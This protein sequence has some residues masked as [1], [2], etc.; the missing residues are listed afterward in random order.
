MVD[1]MTDT[2]LVTGAAGNL[3]RKV[4]DFLL[5]RSPA[6]KIIATTRNPDALSAYAKR[7]VDVRR[8]DFSD[9]A[10]LA[11]A[12]RGATRALLISTDAVGARVEGHKAAIAAFVAAG[13]THVV[14]TSIPNPAGSPAGVAPDHEQ[15]E[16]AIA[17]TSLDYTILRNSLYADLLLGMLPGAIASGTLVDAKGTAALA[18]V[19]REDCARAAAAALGGTHG[20]RATY[21]VTGPKALTGTELASIVSEVTGKPVTYLAVPHQAY[22]DGMISHGL[23]PFLAELFASFDQAT[24]RGDYKT[25]APTVQ[26]LAGIAPTSVKDF[27]IANRAALGV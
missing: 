5:E 24:V 13:V 19:T 4:L 27:L 10:S 11:P 21:D 16:A 20:G 1:R 25:V 23:P 2:L 8:A 15:T 17:A 26:Q 18:W 3:G 14:Y 7:G 6:P 12:F 9:P 22:I